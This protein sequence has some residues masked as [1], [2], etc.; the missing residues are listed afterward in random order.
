MF[1]IFEHFEFFEHKK[2]D[3][4]MFATAKNV[5]YLQNQY[6]LTPEEERV[7]KQAFRVKYLEQ[8]RMWYLVQKENKK[9]KLMQFLSMYKAPAR[10]SRPHTAMQKVRSGE[11]VLRS[12][13]GTIDLGLAFYGRPCSR[14]NNRERFASRG[15]TG[16]DIFGKT[17][18]I[19]PTLERCSSHESL[20]QFYL[21]KLMNEDYAPKLLPYVE[22][23]YSLINELQE[24]V[25]KKCNA[26]PV[27]QFQEPPSIQPNKERL[28]NAR[29]I[30]EDHLIRNSRS[31]RS[32]D[33]FVLKPM[34]TPPTAYNDFFGE[35]KTA[36]IDPP[37]IPAEL[38]KPFGD[39][40]NKED[41]SPERKV[42]FTSQQAAENT[43][44]GRRY[45]SIFLSKTVL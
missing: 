38:S 16:E 10:P 18:P 2:S 31:R 37:F 5:S 3:K 39:F 12:S 32:E 17:A 8:I 6:P 30:R 45:K 43:Q 13:T 26:M 41:A 20:G 34:R 19:A 14:K 25:D 7:L 33:P 29:T 28:I 15:I 4:K 9:R 44:A 1:T 42:K 21:K 11:L 27:A 40:P 24:W 22:D 36:S 35:E 23:Y